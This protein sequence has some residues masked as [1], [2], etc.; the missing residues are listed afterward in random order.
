MIRGVREPPLQQ[1]M[2]A[3]SPVQWWR[4]RTSNH[5]SQKWMMA[6]GKTATKLT[7]SVLTPPECEQRPHSCQNKWF[8]SSSQWYSAEANRP[9][10]GTSC[11]FL[12]IGDRERQWCYLM[13]YVVWPARRTHPG[14]GWEGGIPRV[15]SEWVSSSILY[16]C[17]QVARSTE[18]DK[19][20]GMVTPSAEAPAPGSL[21]WTLVTSCSHSLR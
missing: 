11:V 12:F 7:F 15:R 10:S 3:R 16:F 6:L 21:Y 20:H 19:P 13:K 17:P 5:T 8:F 4:G 9:G 14:N 2:L 1:N 18:K